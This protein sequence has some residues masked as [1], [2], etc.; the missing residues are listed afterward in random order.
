[1]LTYVYLLP[2]CDNLLLTDHADVIENPVINVEDGK[3]SGDELD[4]KDGDDEAYSRSGTDDAA[5][6]TSNST[7]GDLSESDVD[8]LAA[9]ETK[10]LDTEMVETSVPVP[11]PL[12]R[13]RK[14]VTSMIAGTD[15][16]TKLKPKSEKP[17]KIPPKRP[18]ELP[19]N[20]KPK[21]TDL[22][23]AL[24]HWLCSVSLMRSNQWWAQ[25]TE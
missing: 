2:V 22:C 11:V 10:S 16:D 13:R 12:P 9:A 3:S 8:V 4:S 1:M 21:G 14:G 7:R 15:D 19:A 5:E 6:C 20:Y 23:A 24:I 18:G 25:I 17:K